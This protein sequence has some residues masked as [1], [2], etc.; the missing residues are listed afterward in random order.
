MPRRQSGDDPLTP[1]AWAAAI[2][3]HLAPLGLTV[4][5]EPG[6]IL[7]DAAGLLVVEVNTVEEKSSTTWVGVDAGHNV[8]V[9]MAH[10]GIPHEIVHVVATAGAAPGPLLGRRQHQR[11]ERRLRP[12]PAVAEHR[13]GRP[14]RHASGGRL[15]NEHGERPLHAWLGRGSDRLTP[16][17]PG[18]PGPTSQCAASVERHR[19]G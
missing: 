12:R 7:V 19:P 17:I 9:Y 10:Y 6:T 15:R 3:T 1:E 2:R 14:A 16:L 5:C 8:N 11:V 13:G 18:F 4:A